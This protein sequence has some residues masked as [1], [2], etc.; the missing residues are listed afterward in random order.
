[1]L[2]ASLCQYFDPSFSALVIVAWDAYAHV[3]SII[4]G[5]K[6]GPVY[7]PSVS[8]AFRAKNPSACSLAALVEHGKNSSSVDI[9]EKRT[10]LYLDFGHGGENAIYLHI[11]P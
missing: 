8:D 11:G 2:L 9:F 10:P 1:M 3:R 6:K 7:T 5:Q 4:W